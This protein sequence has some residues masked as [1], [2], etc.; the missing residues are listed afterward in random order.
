MA[1][2]LPELR[3]PVMED[4]G[5]ALPLT[6]LFPL[7]TKELWLEIGFGAGE[8]L[9]H[10]A[11]NNPTVGFIGCEL[12]VNGIASLL[13]HIEEN[14]LVNVRIAQVEAGALLAELPDAAIHRAFALFS[15]PW[16]K[17]R[18][19]KRRLIQPTM[20]AELA[21]ILADGAEFRF[22]S[23]SGSFVR[24]TLAHIIGTPQFEWTAESAA[25]WKVPPT[26]ALET[27]YE[28]AA[29]R[30]GRRPIHLTFRRRQR[31]T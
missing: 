8:H 20:L 11:V 25:D 1:E 23:D 26:D 2:S 12:F 3:L 13:R 29:R 7:E 27:R 10:Q 17:K 9:A 31:D 4:C 24:W 5:E 6:Q 30:A 22:A 19:H 18:H 16:P 14:K 15:D 28:A 21:R